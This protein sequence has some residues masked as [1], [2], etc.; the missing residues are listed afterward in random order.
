MMQAA[1]EAALAARA[2]AC[3]LCKWIA[4]DLAKH[5]RLTDDYP[6]QGPIGMDSLFPVAAK[7]AHLKLEGIPIP[8]TISA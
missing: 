1:L 2:D 5:G 6:P 7:E 4:E 3:F 8:R